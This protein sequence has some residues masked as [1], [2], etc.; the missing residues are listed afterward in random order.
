MK[1]KLIDLENHIRGAQR[2]FGLLVG[3]VAQGGYEARARELIAD[4]DSALRTFIMTMLDVRKAV[5]AGYNALHKALIG[6]VVADPLCRQFMT[7]PGV[8]PIAALY[9]RAGVDDPVLFTSS[10]VLGGTLD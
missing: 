10:R 7:A 2:A 5:M 3:N 4:A 1:R 9:F 6:I 8:G